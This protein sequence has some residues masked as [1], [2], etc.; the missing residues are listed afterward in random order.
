MKHYYFGLAAEYLTVFLYKL[1]FYQILQHRM[2]NCAGE[3]DLIALRGKNIVF[4]EV[5]ARSTDGDYG[6]VLRHQQRKRITRAADAFLSRHPKY[7]HYQ[8]RFDLAI[9]RPY[10]LPIIIKNAW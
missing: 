4:I 6:E 5:K 2:R 1:R 10:K 7:Q 3:I 8:V 9:V